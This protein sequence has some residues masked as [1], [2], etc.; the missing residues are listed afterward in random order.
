M[1]PGVGIDARGLWI[2][3]ASAVRDDAGDVPP[4]QVVDG[5]L[6]HQWPATV[7]LRKEVPGQTSEEEGSLLHQWPATVTLRK[8]VPGQTSEEEGSLLH[9]CP[10]CHPDEGGAGPN[11][12]GGRF[13]AP[14]VP[15]LSP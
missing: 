2:A 5:S 13:A 11:V 6:L 14:S 15:P 10:H 9:H 7:T 1:G 8:E 3:T 12:R 4:L